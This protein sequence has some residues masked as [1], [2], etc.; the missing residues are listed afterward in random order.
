[1]SG[2]P[3]N[4]LDKLNLARSIEIELLSRPAVGFDKL[5]DVRGAGV[6]AIY[7][8]GD[9]PSYAPIKA[10]NSDGKYALPIYVGKA[11][12]KGGRKGGISADASAG[13]PLLDRLGQHGA[14][15][16]Q[17]EN[18]S[19]NDFLV[20]HLVVDDIWIPLGEN[21]LIETYKPVWNR[22]LDGFGNKD[23]GRRRATQYKSP[24]D[25]LHPGRRFAEKLA[26]SGLSTDFL[27]ERVRDYLAGRPMKRLPRVIEEQENA[28][29]AEAEE[30]ADNV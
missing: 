30:S 22:A 20:R 14:S 19:I 10:R 7:Y 1:M 4:P 27:D 26:A 6:Y 8:F 23:P 9:F 28:E 13:K 12:P 21:M 3:Y 17:A 29:Q 25:V 18:L 15:I 5:D 16:E 11:I 24:W 2:Q